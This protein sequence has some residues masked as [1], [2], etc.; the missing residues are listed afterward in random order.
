MRM[1]LGR[2][3]V[4]AGRFELLVSVLVLPGCGATGQQMPPGQG[5]NGQG[6]RRDCNQLC[7][8][9]HR[10]SYSSSS[11]APSPTGASASTLTVPMVSSATAAALALL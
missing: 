9:V 2:Y 6:W 4:S 7:T 10:I 11:N 1:G 8:E 3:G 5:I